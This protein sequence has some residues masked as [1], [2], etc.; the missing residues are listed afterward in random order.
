VRGPSLLL[1]ATLLVLAA[2]CALPRLEPSQAMKLNDLDWTVISEP[3][4]PPEDDPS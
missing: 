4:R 1:V 2:A 3:P